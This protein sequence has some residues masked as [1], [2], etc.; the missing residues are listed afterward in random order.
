MI[1]V[2]RR[3]AN[4][5]SRDHTQPSTREGGVSTIARTLVILSPNARLHAQVN[6]CL[7]DTALGRVQCLIMASGGAAERIYKA[8][9]AQVRER[10]E[11]LRMTQLQLSARIGLTR[12]SVANIEGGRQSVLLHQFLDVAAALQVTPE[13]LLPTPIGT[14]PIE[15]ISD[16]PEAVRDAVKTIMRTVRTRAA[17]SR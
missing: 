2:R 13:Q 7:I 12:G 6:A 4:R 17:S 5:R 16:M 3:A 9:G 8:F 10:R 11:A 1:D 15:E 14:P